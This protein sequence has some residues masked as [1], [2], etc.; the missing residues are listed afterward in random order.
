LALGSVVFTSWQFWKRIPLGI[1]KLS[2]LLVMILRGHDRISYPSKHVSAAYDTPLNKCLQGIR[3]LWTNFCGVSDPGELRS[4]SN[5]SANSKPN[6]KIILDMTQG[7]YWADSWEK[8]TRRRKSLATVPLRMGYQEM[9]IVWLWL[10]CVWA[11]W[12]RGWR[13]WE[14]A[15]KK[16]C[17]E[18]SSF[19]DPDL[20]LPG[21][22]NYSTHNRYSNTRLAWH[23]T[24]RERKR[25]RQEEEEKER[26]G[27]KE[28][29][30]GMNWR[31]WLYGGIFWIKSCENTNGSITR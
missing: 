25:Q 27:V 19:L 3:P 5:I 9:R 6:S 17:W 23:N 4:N 11:D 21:K 10:Q 1:G 28:R 8:K 2:K 30:L 31:F 14:W 16:F 13:S 20:N 24:E 29:G 7:P 18:L 26:D 22:E 12:V 15:A